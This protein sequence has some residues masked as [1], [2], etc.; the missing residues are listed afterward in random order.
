[1]EIAKEKVFKVIAKTRFLYAPTGRI[2]DPNDVFE[3]KTQADSDYLTEH[4]LCDVAAE[5]VE[6]TKTQ[7]DIQDEISAGLSTED[8]K[9]AAIEVINEIHNKAAED[10]EV[11]GKPVK[12][13][14]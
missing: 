6:V 13:K 2:Y 14:K 11:T 5:D 7:Q 4:K 3:V 10:V 1:M 8:E 9:I 12:G